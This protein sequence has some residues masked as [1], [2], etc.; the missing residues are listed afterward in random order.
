MTADP[1]AC[2]VRSFISAFGV[3]SRKESAGQNH[4]T[5][6][7]SFTLNNPPSRVDTP[8]TDTPSPPDASPTEMSAINERRA[9][10]PGSMIFSHNPPL[11]EL[12]NDTPPELQPIFG[13]LN[14]HANKL[15]HEGYF[16]KLNDLDIRKLPAHP[17]GR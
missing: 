11:M 2:L 7:A 1:L 8:S 3:S 12:A 6:S 13:Y 15:Y 17:L 5:S 10:R 9:S 4:R 14:S 16:L